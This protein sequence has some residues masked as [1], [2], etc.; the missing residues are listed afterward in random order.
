MRLL[1]VSCKDNLTGLELIACECSYNI[2]CSYLESKMP[3]DSFLGCET[4]DMNTTKIKFKQ[5]NFIHDEKR[6]F[7]LGE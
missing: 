2:A 1:T 7:L 5:R 6:G 3:K 4:I